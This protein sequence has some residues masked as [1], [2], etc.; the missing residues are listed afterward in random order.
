[1]SKLLHGDVSAYQRWEMASFGE[2][3][4]S[5]LAQIEEQQQPIAVEAPPVMLSQDEID[6]IR[7]E[8]QQAGYASGYQEAYEKG[9]REGQEAGYQAADA[10][11]QPEIELMHALAQRFSTQV[12]SAAK[13]TGHQLLA[14]ALDLANNMLKTQLDID[15]AL[16]LPIIE[17]A[18]E[19][20]PAVQLP[21]Q[22]LLHPDDAALVKKLAGER[23]LEA[24]WRISG[25]VNM[26]RGDCL[27]ETA[28]NL[29]DASL[30]TRWERLT[31]A[32]RQVETEV[33]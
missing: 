32:L 20:L 13:D 28:S 11:M 14:L 1:M 31:A 23:F 29:V 26:T 25:D 7:S 27:L 6:A 17:D 33:A 5:H 30:S 21:A 12:S 19:Q 10:S 8:A 22:I 24:G 9:L 3:R 4:P 18:I 15:P 2:T 16:I